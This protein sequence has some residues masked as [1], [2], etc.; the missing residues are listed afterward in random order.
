M[1][2]S[3]ATVLGTCFEAAQSHSRLSAYYPALSSKSHLQRIVFDVASRTGTRRGMVQDGPP[4]R[5]RDG[6]GSGALIRS[7][8]GIDC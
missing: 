7:Q 4:R 6:E 5:N 3:Y 1:H 2:K 8:L